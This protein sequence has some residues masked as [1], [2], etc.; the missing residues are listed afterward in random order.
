MCNPLRKDCSRVNLPGRSKLR[1]QQLQCVGNGSAHTL[2]WAS[3]VQ[4]IFEAGRWGRWPQSSSCSFH[5]GFYM[6]S[7]S[8]LTTSIYIMLCAGGCV[9]LMEW[10]ELM[11]RLG[12]YQV[13]ENSNAYRHHLRHGDAP[14]H[15]RPCNLGWFLTVG[16]SG[17][18]VGHNSWVRTKTITQ[19]LQSSVEL[20]LNLNLGAM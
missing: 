17:V 15:T 8:G 6:D 7:L 12:S 1:C 18:Q 2:S 10:A 11:L 4:T 5:T 16:P 13:T 14:V 9:H 20:P 19:G 3:D